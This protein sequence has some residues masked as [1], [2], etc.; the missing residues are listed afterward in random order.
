MFRFIN[1]LMRLLLRSPFHRVLSRNTLIIAFAGVRSGK[2]YAIPVSYIQDGDTVRCFTAGKWSRNLRGGVPVSVQLRGRTVPGTADV[3]TDD[4]AAVTLG[5]SELLRRVP[6]DARFYKVTLDANHEP[7]VEA[8]ER[9]AQRSVM[10]Q[11][12]LSGVH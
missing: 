12:T 10:I 3:I 8:V 5:L 2:R 9:I 4:K 11:I 7:A 1:V 6:R